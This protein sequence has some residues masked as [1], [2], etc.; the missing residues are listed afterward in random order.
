MLVLAAAIGLLGAMLLFIGS[1]LRT[2]TGTAIRSVPLDWQG[3]VP[4]YA[5]AQHIAA[6]V[7]RQPGVL[8]AT[9]AATA[10]FAGVSHSG[11]A[12]LSNAGAGSLLAVPPGY[13][14]QFPVYRYLQG[15]LEPGQIVLDQQL[16]ATLQARLGDN[17]TIVPR[18]GRTPAHIPGLRGRTD[19][20]AGLPCSSR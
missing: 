12:G 19:H 10:P 5:Q 14:R 3:P 13:E 20:R 8:H 16:A 2:M 6:E 7:G 1:S 17:V 9:A 4:S 18:P 11:P 15:R